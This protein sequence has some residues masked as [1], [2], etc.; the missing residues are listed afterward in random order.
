MRPV[1]KGR[2]GRLPHIGEAGDARTLELAA[3][4]LLDGRPQIGAGLVLDEAKWRATR[5]RSA[6]ARESET[7]ERKWP[8]AKMA[9]RDGQD[10]PT[11][12]AFTAGFGIDNVEAG[13][14]G[15]VLEILVTEHRRKSKS[16]ERQRYTGHGSKG[17]ASSKRQ[18]GKRNQADGGRSNSVQRPYLRA[19]RGQLQR[20]QQTRFSSEPHVDRRGADQPDQT[21][22]DQTNSR[23]GVGKDGRERNPWP[24]D[25]PT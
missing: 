22:Q 12:V 3:V 20:N 5:Q 4:E 15:K 10:V 14:T 18:Q 7:A 16:G 11:T 25:R 13:L 19:Q 8:S 17:R 23:G 24:E 2:E 1:R 21:R 6:R 9:R